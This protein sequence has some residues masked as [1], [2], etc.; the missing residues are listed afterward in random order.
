LQK[1]GIYV[2]SEGRT[3]EARAILD[4]APEHPLTDYMWFTP[5]LLER[6]YDEVLDR[7]SSLSY[8]S[9]KEQQF[10]FQKDLAYASV[11]HA[12]KES[13]LTKTHGEAAQI[14]LKKVIQEYPGDPRYHAALGLTYAYLNRKGEAIQEG[15][16]AVTLYPMTKD[17][18]IGP[19]YILNLAKIYS[20]VGEYDEAINR[21]EYL[22][23][24]PCAEYLWQIVSVPALRLDPQWDPLRENPR[25][26]RL[27]EEK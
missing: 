10:Y 26:Q 24:I 16:R 4:T 27:L 12:M 9:Y 21:L 8:D 14:V 7:L 20:I 6:K 11:Y 22:L 3:E 13:T 2:L 5:G 17:A 23:S 1:A 19:S 18:A 15:N 25:F